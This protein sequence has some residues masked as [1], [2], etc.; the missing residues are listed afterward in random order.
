[1][2]V[3]AEVHV[4][5]LK[6]LSMLGLGKSRVISVPADDQGRMRADSLPDLNE[7][8]ILC[9]QAGN[10]NTGSFDPAG[11]ICRHA[12]KA[13]SWVHVD[14]AF[15]MWAAAAPQRAHLFQG[16]ADADSWATDCHK[17][18]NVPYDSGI[19]F[20]RNSQHLRD[21]ME[22]SAAY[23]HAGG[24]R[25]PAH[26]TPDASRRA[27]GVEIWAALK[28]L[29]RAGLAEM[30]ERNCRLATRFA[31][32]LARAGYPVL[33][34]VVLNQVLV[35][36]GNTDVNQRIISAIQQEGTCWCG[37]TE[38]QGKSAMRI[39]VS[40]WATTEQDVDRSLAA[41]IKTATELSGN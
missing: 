5:V 22:I 8:T 26:Y 16:F 34:D 15:G 14:A 21:A 27:R 24:A 40:C 39:S 18:L 12:R 10:V 28:S 37:G 29:G 3:S 41:I 30:V 38:W 23:L 11:E 6:A 2:V 1:V 9:N 19:A 35:S 17:W 4:S 36:F 20:V 13:G 32:G 31:Q 33:N 25:Q 7:H